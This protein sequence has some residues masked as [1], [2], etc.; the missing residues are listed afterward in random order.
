MSQQGSGKPTSVAVETVG[1][2]TT[3]IPVEISTRFLEN[4]SE[5]LYS[6]PQKAFEEL[7]A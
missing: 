5:Q 6:S 2:I 1:H 4:F 7:R 3:E